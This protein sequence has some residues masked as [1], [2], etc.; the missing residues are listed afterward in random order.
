MQ[1]CHSLILVVTRPTYFSLLD[2][3]FKWFF[4]QEQY[5]FIELVLWQHVKQQPSA[6]IAFIVDLLHTK[7]HYSM[8]GIQHLQR[9]SIHMYLV[10][11][12]ISYALHIFD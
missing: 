11:S 8:A 5:R 9:L 1:F 6:R 7:L 10:L 12:F 3:A 2:E 4:V